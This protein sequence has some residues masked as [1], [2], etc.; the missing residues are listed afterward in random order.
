[1][2]RVVEHSVPE[3]VPAGHLPLP[4]GARCQA[5]HVDRP[6]S[7]PLRQ[8]RLGVGGEVRGVDDSVNMLTMNDFGL[9]GP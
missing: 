1:M 3:V 9:K 4:L 6:V 2:L 8:G 7:L 5:S